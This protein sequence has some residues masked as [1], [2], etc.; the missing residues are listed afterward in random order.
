MEEMAHDTH[1]AG[2]VDQVGFETD[3]TAHGDQGLNR[4]DVPDVVHVCDLRLAEGEVL[5]HRAKVLVGNFHKQFLDWLERLSVRTFFPK[6]FGT[7]DEYF[8]AFAPH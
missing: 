7:G 6:D 5:H 1:T 4:N 8:V 3:Q 2:H